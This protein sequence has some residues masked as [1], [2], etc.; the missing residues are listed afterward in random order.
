MLIPVG[1]GAWLQEGWPWGKQPGLLSVGAVLGSGSVPLRAPSLG[2]LVGDLTV[3]EGRGVSRVC[4]CLEE[5]T[6]FYRTKRPAS[7]KLPSPTLYGSVGKGL[8]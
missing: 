2:D 8:Q 7:I 1:M 5:P 4:V 3:R 6:A